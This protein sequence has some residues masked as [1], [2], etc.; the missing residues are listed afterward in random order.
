M[1]R[2]ILLLAAKL[3]VMLLGAPGVGK[4]AVV[5]RF[6]QE[7]G[8]DLVDIRLYAVLHLNVLVRI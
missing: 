3:P 6:A 8:A 1:D 4:T 2:N 5:T 7:L